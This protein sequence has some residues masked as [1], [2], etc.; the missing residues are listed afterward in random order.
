MFQYSMNNMKIKG[1]SQFSQLIFLLFQI[2]RD[3]SDSRQLVIKNY[4]Y[5]I[6]HSEIINIS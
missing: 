4:S 2:I 6:K 1:I 3:I 5:F